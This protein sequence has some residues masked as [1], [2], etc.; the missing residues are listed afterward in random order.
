MTS[1]PFDPVAS[2]EK[3]SAFY[4]ATTRPLENLFLLY[5]NNLSPRLPDSNSP[6]YSDT[7]DEPPVFFEKT[8]MTEPD[9]DLPF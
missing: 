3:K 5:S 7:K 4:V 9:F 6:I 8:K 2:E 1:G